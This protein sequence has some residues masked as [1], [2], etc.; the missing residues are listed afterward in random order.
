MAAYGREAGGPLDATAVNRIVGWLR[1]QGPKAE[2]LPP[3]GQGDSARGAP[4]YDKNC[5]PC[6]GDHDT[7]GEG[8][9]LANSRL[10]DAVSDGFMKYAIVK[11]RPGT[12]MEAWSG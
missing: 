6:H 12:R 10:L 5:R 7:R 11:G 3:A 2:P 8:I 4:I 1:A 9:W